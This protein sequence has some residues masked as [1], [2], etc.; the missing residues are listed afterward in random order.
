MKIALTTVDPDDRDSCDRLQT[1][2]VRGKD[3]LLYWGAGCTMKRGQM[4]ALYTPKSPFLPPAEH[5][6]IRAV[7]FAAS[8]STKG[9]TWNQHVFLFKRTDLSPPILHSELTGEMGIHF[10]RICSAGKIAKDLPGELQDKLVRA[11]EER[12]AG[13][14]PEL[15]TRA[16][17]ARQSPQVS[18]SYSGFESVLA[19]RL[20]VWLSGLGVDPFLVTSAGKVPVADKPP[21]KRLLQTVFSQARLVIC[22][23][24]AKE[25]MSNWIKLELTSAAS[26]A[27]ALLLA[28]PD[29]NR[30]WPKFIAGRNIHRLTFGKA[31]EVQVLVKVK[32]LITQ[33]N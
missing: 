4:V 31:C 16:N 25:G 18:I 9:E 10:R 14:R 29:T 11:V 17:S 28:R 3:E 7:Y 19:L 26:H 2:F 24:P 33:P 22:I 15:L 23:V 21:L 6:R 13:G 27:P 8:D 1:A 12:C 5:S 32:G 30:P 20:R